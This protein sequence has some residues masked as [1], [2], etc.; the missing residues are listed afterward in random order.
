MGDGV[1]VA[2]GDGV[3]VA[4]GDGVVSGETVAL[5]NDVGVESCCSFSLASTSLAST[6]ASTARSWEILASTVA[7]ILGV[8]SIGAGAALEHATRVIQVQTTI[9]I[10]NFKSPSQ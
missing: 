3:G 1:G 2:V 6:V 4:V 8:F 5:G 9:N 7:S 10:D